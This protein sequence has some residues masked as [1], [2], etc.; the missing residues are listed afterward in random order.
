M[1]RARHLP[2]IPRAH[3]FSII[4]IDREEGLMGVGVQSHW[5]SVGS[6]VA[7][8]EAGVGVVATQAMVEVGYGPR[9]L[10][11]LRAGKTPAEALAELLAEDAQRE[12]RQ[13]AMLSV[14][15]PAAAHTGALCIA[16]A[17]HICEADFSV[18]ANMMVNGRVWP[19]M[20]NAYRSEHGNFTR[21][22][23]A[24]LQAGQ[25]AGGDIRGQQ[26]AALVIVRTTASDRPWEDRVLDLRV[27]DHPEPIAE[28]T[29]LVQVAEAYDL[30]DRGDQHISRGE[31]EAAM[32]AYAQA[33]ALAPHIAELPYWEAVTLADLG[34]LEEALPIFR[35]VF[36]RDPNLI[37]LTRRLVPANILHVTAETLEIICAQ[38]N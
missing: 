24:A 30:M 33:A 26:S 29:R 19:A 13:V 12:V 25:E 9:G 7:W 35:D 3:T 28:L 23:L 22:M 36:R 20:A 10:S 21:R 37:A 18:Q 11:A 15:A 5:F 6:R 34:H 16:D 2:D 17:G 14:N 31:T 8:A 32:Q 4:A 38:G 1:K 27:E